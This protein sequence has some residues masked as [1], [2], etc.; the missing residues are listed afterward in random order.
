MVIKCTLSVPP[1]NIRY[2]VRQL[3]QLPPLPEYITKNGPYVNNREGVA[4]QI[5]ITYKFSKSKFAEAR[6]NISSQLRSLHGLP[7]F[8][9]SAHTYGPHPSHLILEK[10]QQVRHY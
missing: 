1:E 2:Y 4:H 6:E 9:L 3:S 8:T 5:I 10:S 7:G